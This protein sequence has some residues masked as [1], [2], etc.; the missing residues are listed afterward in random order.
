[1]KAY[2]FDFAKRKALASELQKIM[3]EELPIIP[4][5]SR[6]AILATSE[7][8]GNAEAFTANAYGVQEFLAVIFRRR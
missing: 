3:A 7:A 8:L 2:N 5:W 4:L 1:M 6:K